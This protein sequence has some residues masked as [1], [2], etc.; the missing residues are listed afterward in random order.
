MSEDGWR[1][2]IRWVV[3]HPTQ[4][5]VLLLA[6][7]DGA[8]CLPRT[9]RPGQVW[10]AEPGQVLPG[11]RDLLGADALL[12]RCLD[13]HEDPSARVQR[14]TLLA[15]PRALPALP[16]GLAW[17]GRAELAG[18]A[19]DGDAALAARV[20]EQLAGRGAGPA[21][22]PWAARGW[23]AGAER[24]LHDAMAAIG[25]PLTGPVE[26]V[27][28]WDLSCVLRAPTAAGVVW[29]KATAASPLFVNEGPVMVALAGL[30]G[31]RVPAPL[32]VDPGRGWMV[33]DD[34]GRRSA[35]RRPWRWSRRWSGRSPGCRWRPP[36][37]PTGCWPPAA[38][39]AAWTGWP[40][41]RGHG[42]R[43]SGPPGSWPASTTPPG[44]REDEQ[45]AVR[46]ALPQVLAGCQELAGHAVPPSL[47]HGDLHLGNVARGPA[48]YRF[49]DWTDA[50]VAHPFF[51]L[52]TLRRGTGFAGEE[53]RRRAA[54]PAAGRL[55]PGVGA[56]RAARAP[57]PG[58]PAGG[59]ARGPAPRGQLPLARG[60]D[61]AA[62]RVPHGRVDGLVAAP[63]AGRPGRP[64]LG[65]AGP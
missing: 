54:R 32:A 24:W 5:R 26:Q 58:P 51:D 57:G 42:C 28:V 65:S 15:E 19:G 8:R 34:L 62:G 23:F 44:C 45:A 7:R 55:P 36:A 21:G 25:R 2:S 12:L 63:D 40:T 41:R 37:R 14:A 6:G 59:P 27:Q 17:A 29:F 49:F 3:A 47:V 35:G 18:A 22:R 52:L 46:A 38:T 43:R 20:V 13:E 56:V 30:F 1:T 60:R 4:A 39:T 31:D 64:K 48:G 10:T 61:D 53:S 50:C 16:D 11:L 9:E 33:L